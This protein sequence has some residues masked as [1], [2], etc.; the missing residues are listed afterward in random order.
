V[1]TRWSSFDG[2]VFE[3]KKQ[4]KDGMSVKKTSFT[5]H[6]NLADVLDTPLGFTKIRSK[7]LDVLFKA[8]FFKQN[9]LSNLA[10]KAAVVSSALICEG[11]KGSNLTSADTEKSVSEKSEGNM[12]ITSTSA[13]AHID[14][15][16]IKEFKPKSMFHEGNYV[17]TPQSHQMNLIAAHNSALTQAEVYLY[18]ATDGSYRPCEPITV[19]RNSFSNGIYNGSKSIEAYIPFPID[20]DS[21]FQINQQS[22]CRPFSFSGN[23]SGCGIMSSSPVRMVNHSYENPSTYLASSLFKEDCKAPT[24]SKRLNKVTSSSSESTSSD[25]N[26]SIPGLNYT[27]VKSKRK[28][29]KKRNKKSRSCGHMFPDGINCLSGKHEN[30]GITDALNGNE[31]SVFM[32]EEIELELTDDLAESLVNPPIESESSSLVMPI[33]RDDSNDNNLTGDIADLPAEPQLKSLMNSTISGGVHEDSM[34]AKVASLNYGGALAQEEDNAGK[35]ILVTRDFK[36]SLKNNLHP[37]YGSSKVT[38]VDDEFDSQNCELLDEFPDIQSH[39]PPRNEIVQRCKTDAMLLSDF[40]DDSSNLSPV[41]VAKTIERTTYV[42]KSKSEDSS[43][44]PADYDCKLIASMNSNDELPKQANFQ[45]P[46]FPLG[47][48]PDNFYTNRSASSG[49]QKEK[50]SR[51]RR[52]RRKASKTGAENSQKIMICD[53]QVENSSISYGTGNI[54]KEADM[55]KSIEYICVKEL[56]WGMLKGS[57]NSGRKVIGSYVPP[58]RIKGD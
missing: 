18:S 25:R 38:D 16:D 24:V 56:G 13:F 26:I 5:G 49:G 14:P 50:S 28:R 15:N 36:E 57:M 53:D 12:V 44:K 54:T 3:C 37:D 21:S 39:K 9:Y 58:L 30:A 33:G 48:E 45:V 42:D 41:V 17:S 27:G 55:M 10:E 4:V 35:W 8:D 2:C 20:S 19:S 6:D 51:G 32:C 46:N 34:V 52:S 43:T 47:S 11:F 29:A 23:D 40:E 1:K 22:T 31:N 7:H